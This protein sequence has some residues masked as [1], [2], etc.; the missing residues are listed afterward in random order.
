M[1]ISVSKRCSMGVICLCLFLP[2][3]LFAGQSHPGYQRAMDDLRLARTL[4]ERPNRVQPVNDA[5]DEVSLAL[6]NMTGAMKQIDQAMGPDQ[7]KPEQLPKIDARMRWSEHLDQSLRLIDRAELECSKEKGGSAQANAKVFD[8]LNQAS[9]RLSVA[10]Q[11]VNF[12]YS[13]RNLPTRND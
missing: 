6:E 4:L 3:G 5:P 12:D 11:T 10:L 1:F 9:T 13:S 8:L 2:G 7:G